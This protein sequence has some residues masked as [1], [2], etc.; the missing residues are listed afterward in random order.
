MTLI[1]GD[2]VVIK[3][4]GKILT[5]QD[6]AYHE[7]EVIADPI[8]TARSSDGKPVYVVVLKVVK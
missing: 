2:H 7:F 3:R 8:C 4:N 6:E 5:E 1:N